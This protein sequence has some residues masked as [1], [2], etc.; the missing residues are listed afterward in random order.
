MDAEADSEKR[1]PLK[2]SADPVL[3]SHAKQISSSL[4]NCKT[5]MQVEGVGEL[6]IRSFVAAEGRE[7]HTD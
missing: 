1:K 6:L 2:F 4:T 3:V 7:G 5:R